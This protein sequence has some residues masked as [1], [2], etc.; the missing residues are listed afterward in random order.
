M[1]TFLETAIAGLL[2]RKGWETRGDREMMTRFVSH[3]FAVCGWPKCET[4]RFFATLSAIC[5]GPAAFDPSE[6]VSS[7]YV[8]VEA[9]Q[10][11]WNEDALVALIGWDGAGA[12]SRWAFDRRCPEFRD[13][14]KKQEKRRGTLNRDR[15]PT[16]AQTAGTVLS[17]FLTYYKPLDSGTDDPTANQGWGWNLTVGPR[18][19]EQIVRRACAE[20]L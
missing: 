15:L 9:G 20:F 16:L 6:A 10:I 2:L 7:G 14:M 18:T 13:Q 5:D 4:Q 19:A 12:L 1:P 11:A 8:D 3:Q 17:E